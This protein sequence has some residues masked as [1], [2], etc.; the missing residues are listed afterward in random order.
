MPQ[1]D[2]RMY[3]ED[4]ILH[5]EAVVVS[6]ADQTEAGYHSNMDLRLITERRMEIVGEAVR[7]LCL[8]HPPL[9]ARF[10]GA[11]EIIGF[12]NILVHAYHIVE[13]G[14]VWRVVGDHLPTL[15]R[16]ARTLLNE[17]GG[18]HPRGPLAAPTGKGG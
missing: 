7:Q 3:L 8:E 13:H 17:L 12:R 11:R 16:E 4:I 1:R 6:L 9:K 18:P 2:P 15:I 14:I 10:T 5:G